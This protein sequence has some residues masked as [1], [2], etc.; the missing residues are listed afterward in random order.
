MPSTGHS[1]K[2]SCIHAKHQ[3]FASPWEGYRPVR[4]GPCGSGKTFLPAPGSLQDT[5]VDKSFFLERQVSSLFGSGS[6]GLGRLS[7]FSKPGGVESLCL[8]V[9]LFS[10]CLDP[11]F[12]LPPI[13]IS[14]PFF[15]EIFKFLEKFCEKFSVLPSF[16]AALVSH[17]VG[18]QRQTVCGFQERWETYIRLVP[19]NRSTA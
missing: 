4:G 13:Q 16:E 10:L 15:Q 6:A 11:L 18:E 9:E 19:F 14:G 7:S 3:N 12:T 17:R 2:L 8:A 1:F 5:T